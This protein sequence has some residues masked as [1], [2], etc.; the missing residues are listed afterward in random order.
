MVS[1]RHQMPSTSSGQ[2]DE[3]ATANASPT[4]V[5][6]GSDRAAPASANGTTT[7]STVA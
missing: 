7:A 2:N 4:T 6:T 3:A 1:L 5:A